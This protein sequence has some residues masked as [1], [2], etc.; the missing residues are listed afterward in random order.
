MEKRI[1]CGKC[2][3]EYY[4]RIAKESQD[5]SCPVCGHGKVSEAIQEGGKKKILLDRREYL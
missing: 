3:S 1:K 2:Q 4:P 5:F